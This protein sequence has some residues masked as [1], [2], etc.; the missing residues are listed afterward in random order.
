[1][2]SRKIR[3]ANRSSLSRD[4]GPQGLHGNVFGQLAVIAAAVS[5]AL[6][7]TFS[8]RYLRGVAPVLQSFAVLLIADAMLWLAV[9]VAE[10]PL[11]WPSLPMTW[12]A[13][14]WLGVLGSCTAYLMFFWLINAW[15]PTR[16]SL[17]TYVFPVIGLLLGII[18]LGETADWRLLAGSLLI[19]GGILVVNL[20][21]FSWITQMF[22]PAVA[23]E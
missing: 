3:Q 4:V 6:A 8:R 19:V 7:I 16:A 9:P 14:A 15:G 2:N 1:M 12:L 11:I 18:F 23:T 5:Y 17:V 13:L 10:K 21:Q 20:K 22:R